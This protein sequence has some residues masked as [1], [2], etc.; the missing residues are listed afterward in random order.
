M[1]D[2]KLN[3]QL[4]QFF[5]ANL[6]VPKNALAFL[7]YNYFNVRKRYIKYL[8]KG[9]LTEKR[10]Y[11]ENLL[12]ITQKGLLTFSSMDHSY[13]SEIA[14]YLKRYVKYSDSKQRQIRFVY[15]SAMIYHLIPTITKQYLDSIEKDILDLNSSHF[16]NSVENSFEFSKQHLNS[17]VPALLQYDSL[18]DKIRRHIIYLSTQN[19]NH[20]WFI[21]MR[22]LRMLDKHKP[23]S[24]GLKKMSLIRAQG[25]L[26]LNMKNFIVY[27]SM[28]KR[29]KTSCRYEN[30]FIQF[31]ET[32]LRQS[33]DSAIFFAKSYNP[34]YKTICEAPDSSLQ[35]VLIDG[36]NLYEHQYYVPLTTGGAKQLDIY[37]IPK[38]REI[39]AYYLIPEKYRDHAK[40]V[41]FDGETE[42]HDLYYLGFYCDLIEIRK[43]YRS[44]QGV[45]KGTK[46]NIFCFSWQAKFYHDLFGDA[47]DITIVKDEDFISFIRSKI[48]E[49]I[50]LQRS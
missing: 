4:L 23:G 28:S 43:L 20:N 26:H 41:I 6:I 48:Q 24:Y 50:S 12:R 10:S 17:S 13:H 32:I 42:L 46:I 25:I 29:L 11:N 36:S 7:G 33:I 44:M 47:A 9:L 19:P 3:Y 14:D 27:N 8:Q 18:T 22:E 49:N 39:S 45:R 40:N 15:S 30:Q 16:L 2:R 5:S 35:R 1:V 38:F 37:A 21:T 34:A 31:A